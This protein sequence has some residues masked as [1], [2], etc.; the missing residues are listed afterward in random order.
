MLASLRVS[1]HRGNILYLKFATQKYRTT[2]SCL[3]NYNLLFYSE[4]KRD[5]TNYSLK[6]THTAVLFENMY[7]YCTYLTKTKIL[8]MLGTGYFLKIAKLNSQREKPICP[9]RKNQFPQNT[10]NR[11]SAKINS[12]KDYVP[13]GNI[14]LKPPKR[15]PLIKIHQKK[16]KEPQKLST[17]R[18]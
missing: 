5:T 11:Q 2:K 12:R 13:H 16:R 7:L 4:T 3:F 14:R 1:K 15:P 10:K 9:N 18:F 6:S 8:S 17:C